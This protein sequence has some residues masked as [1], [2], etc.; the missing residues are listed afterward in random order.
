MPRHDK[1]KINGANGQTGGK[2]T[3]STFVLTAI[4]SFGLF[5]VFRIPMGTAIA[6]AF[7]LRPFI[8]S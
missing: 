8:V 4:I 5:N 6:S 7:N 1:V 2:N 3:S